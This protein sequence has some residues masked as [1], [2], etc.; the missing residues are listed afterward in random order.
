MRYTIGNTIVIIEQTPYVKVFVCV[1]VYQHISERV[2]L[3]RTCVRMH[4]L[5]HL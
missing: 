3:N 5:A 1:C 2:I 4:L